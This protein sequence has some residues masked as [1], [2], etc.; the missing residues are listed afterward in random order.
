[1]ARA[2]GDLVAVCG[3][4]ELRQKLY[5]Y[6]R[7]ELD[8]PADLDAVRQHLQECADCAGV[9]GELQWLLGTMR[10]PGGADYEQEMGRELGRLLRPAEPAAPPRRAA[11]L[12]RL[13]HWISTRGGAPQ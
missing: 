6:V 11:W 7:G 2:R 1:V 5:R 8:D 3:R 9:H 10:R 13:K 12:A 4:P